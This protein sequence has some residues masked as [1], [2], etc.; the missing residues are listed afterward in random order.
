MTLETI[1]KG[2]LAAEL[3][4][5]TAD[6]DVSERAVAGLLRAPLRRWGLSPRREVL[7]YARE[8][9]R[10]C[11]VE[12]LDAV[13][14]VLSRLV[15]LGECEEVFVGHERY[16]APAEPRW[17]PVGN[18]MGALLSVGELPEGIRPITPADHRDIVRRFFVESDEEAATLHVAGVTETTV[19]DWRT[20]AAYVRH[21]S[22]RLRRP[23]RTEAVGLSDFWDVLVRALSQEGLPRGPNAELR[24]VS[25]EPGGY[26][27]RHDAAKP[28]GRWSE[29]AQDG[30]WCG[31]RRGYGD[32]HWH[33]VL[34]AVD[35]HERRALDLYDQDEWRWALL[36]RGAAV[37][38][39]EVVRREDQTV[40]FTFPIPIQLSAAMQLV[41]VRSGAWSWELHPGAPK[42]AWLLR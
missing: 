40:V 23:A 29:D 25:G 33:P 11:G 37:G 1:T 28:E 15:A 10:A 35:G 8:Q 6:G 32:S 4:I 5:L 26:F 21:A 18:G 7:R 42:V 12:D 24:T 22:R 30:I 39:A 17:M 34:V 19:E 2:Q 9:L 38:A 14:R 3:G 27:G 36:A 16:V 13:P 20:P 31:F 41:G